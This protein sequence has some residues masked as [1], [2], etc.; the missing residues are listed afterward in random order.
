MR[1][2]TASSL[3]AGMSIGDGAAPDR[4]CINLVEGDFVIMASDGI[5]DGSDDGKLLEFLSKTD[6]TSPKALA[7]AILAYSFAV[8]GKNDDMTVAVVKIEAE[9]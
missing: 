9:E 5:S 4:T 6:E 7:D 2:I 1:R 8:Y 3:P